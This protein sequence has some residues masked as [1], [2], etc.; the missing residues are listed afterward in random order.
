MC[1]A[2][3]GPVDERDAIR[4]DEQVASVAGKF[5]STNEGAAG[6]TSWAADAAGA[7][8]ACW[9]AHWSKQVRRA[10]LSLI[11]AQRCHAA[12]GACACAAGLASRAASARATGVTFRGMTQEGMVG[13]FRT[14]LGRKF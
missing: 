7:C 2:S 12:L 10:A 9:P 4:D 11:A 8:Q 14:G 3:N 13:F 5:V 6:G 1:D